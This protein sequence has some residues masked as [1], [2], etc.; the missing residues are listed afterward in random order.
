MRTGRTS[1][2]NSTKKLDCEGQAEKAVVASKGV[3]MPNTQQKDAGALRLKLWLGV[4]AS[5]KEYFF[6]C[7]LPP[8]YNSSFWRGHLLIAIKVYVS[9]SYFRGGYE[10]LGL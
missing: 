1:I 6:Q 10:S 3:V 5:R 2:C 4:E 9:S 7:D 8:F